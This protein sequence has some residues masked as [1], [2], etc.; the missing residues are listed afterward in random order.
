MKTV[1][2]TGATGLIGQE[3]V[4]VCHD[5]KWVVH[6]LTTSKQKLSKEDN[7]KGFYWNPKTKQIDTTC[8]EGVDAI[9]N[10]VG[11]TISKRWTS[12][13]KKE[14]IASRTDT[15][16]LLFDTIKTNHIVIKQFVSASAIGIYPSSQTNYYE[17]DFQNKSDSFLGQVVDKW[18]D[19]I[20]HFSTLGITVSKIRIGLVLSE[21][22]GALPEITKP[23]RFGAGAAFG[24]GQQWQSWIHIED[25]AQLFVYAINNNLDGIYN[26]VA[27]NP[28]SNLELTKTAARVLNKPLILPNIP[29]FAM[30]LILGEMHILLF[31]SQR[32]SSQKIENAGFNFKHHH[33]EPA[34][35]TL[36]Y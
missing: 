24:D 6:Y 29:K 28:V 36:L 7:Y 23:I 15:A 9:I 31:E 21:K 30:K 18:E 34:L 11:A 16:S 2:I 35:Q 17:E 3:I 14:I 1:L 10:L 26:G 8:F 33:L 20:D 27:P 13:Y 32:V 4:K 19:A 5:N 25:L 22:G 12:D